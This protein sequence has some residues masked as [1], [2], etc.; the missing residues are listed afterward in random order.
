M[1]AGEYVPAVAADEFVGQTA[2]GRVVTGPA[3]VGLGDVR[4]D[5]RVRLD[6]LA[7]F[8]QDVADVDVESA[9]IDD[10]DG[11]W[12]LRRLSMRIART[13]RFR[14]E[15]TLATWCSGTGARWAERR[16]DIA[17]A[18]D[19]CVETVG[20]WVHVDRATGR[21]KPLPVGFE[22]VWGEQARARRV[23]ARLSQGPAPDGAPRQRWPLRAT[24]VD[25]VGHV[26]NAAYWAAVEEEIARRSIRHVLAATIEFG[27]GIDP[28]ETVDL[29]VAD[30][31]GGFM[32]WFLVGGEARASAS[33]HST[34]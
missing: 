32:C 21:P 17:R 30:H 20:L 28:N 15:L 12:V 3:R 10:P 29:A 25:V 2:G 26:N 34:T 6:A 23:R 18:G 16:T 1:G 33:V 8:M 19:V 14:D 11:V 31:E 9:Q 22:H 13:P 7:C 24:D 4:P 27:G 5:G